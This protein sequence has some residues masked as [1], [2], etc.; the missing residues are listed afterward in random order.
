M[1]ARI[2]LG[3]AFLFS[4]ITSMTVLAK[5]GFAFITITG[6]NL[7][8]PIRAADPALTD[9]FFA[10]ADFYRSKVKEPTD[11]GVGYEITRYYVNGNQETAFDS[12]HYYPDT[13]YVYYDGI[14]NGGSEY[15][16]K[17]YT[18]IPEIKTAFENALIG[19]TS[20]IAPAAE[21]KPV[22]SPDP[23]QAASSI[24]QNQP[25]LIIVL[26]TGF[27]LILLFAQR[28]RKPSTQ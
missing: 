3:I 1:F 16:K 9:D 28:L 2:P 27:V 17:W 15:D 22:T 5:G 19:G 12:L 25:I 6:P 14:A 8:E 18:A 10:F 20:S 13:G 26:L 11:P 24:V 23:T 7:K 4:L 21:K